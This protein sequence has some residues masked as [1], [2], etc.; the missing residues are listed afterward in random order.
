MDVLALT[1]ILHRT[2]K[3][4]NIDDPINPA[5]YRQSGLEII[6]VIEAYGL[7]F[8]LGNAVKYISRAGKKSDKAIEDLQKAAWYLQREIERL[9]NASQGS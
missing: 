2:K 7:G 3:M 4:S 6:T 1:P 8:C 9:Q 5:Y